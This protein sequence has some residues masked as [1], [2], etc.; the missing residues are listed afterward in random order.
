[1]LSSVGAQTYKLLKSL[2]VPSKLADKMFQES[3][4]I[5]IKHQDA[6]PDSIAENFKFINRDR[7][8]EESIAEYF[9]ELRLLAEHCNYDT[10]FQ[11][12]LRDQLICGVKHES[13]R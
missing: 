6:K 5:I 7:K 8:P 12:M 11:D 2:S 13:I 1:M 4:Q 10:I 9:A 3:V